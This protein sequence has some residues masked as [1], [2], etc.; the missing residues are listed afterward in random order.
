MLDTRG[1][2][3]DGRTDTV[4]VSDVTAVTASPIALWISL[5]GPSTARGP[6]VQADTYTVSLES[7][8][9]GE[10][11][12]LYGQG[13]RK[14]CVGLIIRWFDS[15]LNQGA[16]GAM[17]C[18]AVLRS[19]DETITDKDLIVWFLSATYPGRKLIPYRATFLER[20]RVR[21]SRQIG[22]E[23]ANALAAE[24]A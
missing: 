9:L 13:L 8:F 12:K 2:S 5:M 18:D 4:F 6:T 7:A 3:L 22:A 20:A 23:E 21:L 14:R 19:I 11:Y 15:E 10:V 17:R 1:L 24:L 16:A